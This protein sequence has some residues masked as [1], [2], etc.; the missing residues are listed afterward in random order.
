MQFAPGCPG[1]REDDDQE[2]G[3]N[4]F[5]LTMSP[6]HHRG[7]DLEVPWSRNKVTPSVDC[8]SCC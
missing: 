8:D 4:G 1:R 2:G 5:V 7:I 3:S 6:P